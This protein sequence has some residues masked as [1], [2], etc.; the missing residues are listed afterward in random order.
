[1]VERRAARGQSI[2]EMVTFAYR[3]PRPKGRAALRRAR[4]VT[5]HILTHYGLFRVECGR[6][7]GPG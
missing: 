4:E 1:L 3:L 2:G 5:H 6:A 7:G